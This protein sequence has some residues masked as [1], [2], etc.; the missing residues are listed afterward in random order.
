MDD[1]GIGPN[2]ESPIDGNDYM[3]MSTVE[4]AGTKYVADES[5]IEKV[6]NDDAGNKKT[7]DNVRII[8]TPSDTPF[9][10]ELGYSVV[11]FRTEVTDY[12][13]LVIKNRFE[14]QDGT[15]GWVFWDGT[16]NIN[17]Q[18]FSPAIITGCTDDAAVNYNPN[19]NSDDGSCIAALDGCTDPAMFNYNPNANNDD[20][21]CI[22]YVYGCTDINAFN[23]DANANTDDN[24]CCYA[25]GCTDP[26]AC[27]YDSNACYDDGSCLHNFGC[28]DP[29]AA[30]Y[31][32]AAD[33]DDG[34]CC[35]ISGCTDPTACNYNSNACH[36][37]GSC[38]YAAANEDCS[39]NCLGDT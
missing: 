37:D 2:V 22:A 12:Q 1:T 30:N 18:I 7:F 19:A 13:H 3:S 26:T 15:D 28:T 35:Y 34:S 25:S 38:I 23:Y 24:S 33:C 4:L 17:A 20:G 16:Q 36:D 10:N 39:G 31:D 9:E 27:N 8:M 6:I 29:T 5:Y 21:S 32:N 11:D 14:F